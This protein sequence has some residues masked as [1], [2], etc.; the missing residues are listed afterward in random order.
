MPFIHP[1]LLWLGVCGI[2]IPIAIH[3]FNR[4]RFK[5]VD[6]AAMRFLMDAMRK[7]RRRLRVE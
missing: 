7:N 4:R 6:F 5:V 2:S 3:I 1:L